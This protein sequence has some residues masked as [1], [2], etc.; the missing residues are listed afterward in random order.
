MVG[1]FALAPKLARRQAQAKIGMTGGVSVTV[2][3]RHGGTSF[4]YQ[5][6][7]YRG[8]LREIAGTVEIIIPV[9]LVGNGVCAGR[10]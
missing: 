7:R 8:G 6:H 2:N 5:H 10:I 4:H 3:V 1:S 9:L